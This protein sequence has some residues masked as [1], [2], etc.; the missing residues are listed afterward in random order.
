MLYKHN[1]DYI[2]LPIW[3]TGHFLH[4]LLLCTF[5]ESGAVTVF[6]SHRPS[7]SAPEC[8]THR[9]CKLNKFLTRHYLDEKDCSTTLQWY[10]DLRCCFLYIQNHQQLSPSSGR[11][12]NGP[13]L[14][15][16]SVELTAAFHGWK[17]GLGGGGEAERGL[18]ASQTFL[19]EQLLKISSCSHG[20]L[21]YFGSPK[22]IPIYQ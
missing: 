19:V 20:V 2:K 6:F 4:L 8:L 12:T 15:S 1:W 13:H 14:P 11:S 3:I 10:Q 16:D 21:S 9:R 18:T 17:L 22:L 7:T 5:H